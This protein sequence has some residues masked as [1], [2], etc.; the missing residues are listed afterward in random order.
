MKAV[1][2]ILYCV[3]SELGDWMGYSLAWGGS[4]LAATGRRVVA[5]ISSADSADCWPLACHTRA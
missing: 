2:T 1:C 4:H 5:L 3:I